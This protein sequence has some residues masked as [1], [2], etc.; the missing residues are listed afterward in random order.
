MSDRAHFE[1]LL[2]DLCKELEGD[3]DN[4]HTDHLRL[5]KKEVIELQKTLESLDD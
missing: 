4:I 1:Q 2:K 5:I 3:L